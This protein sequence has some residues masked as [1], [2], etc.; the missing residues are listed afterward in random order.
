MARQRTVAIEGAH[1]APGSRSP[2]IF[3]RRHP[4]SF[5]TA[6]SSARL[7][8]VLLKPSSWFSASGLPSHFFA[9]FMAEFPES[10]VVPQTHLP[11]FHFHKSGGTDFITNT[12][13]FH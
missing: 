8:A 10:K 7:S 4:P 13:N 1:S 3:A 5:G 12:H 6:H 2:P 11:G 9:P